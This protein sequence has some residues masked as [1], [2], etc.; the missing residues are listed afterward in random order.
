MALPFFFEAKM[1]TIAC[2]RI[3]QGFSPDYVNVLYDSVRRNLPA[4][5]E[6]RFVC[7]TDQPDEL[8]PGIEIRSTDEIFYYQGPTLWLKLNWCVVGPLDEIAQRGKILPEDVT[9]YTGAL[10]PRG[11]KI[12]SFPLDKLQAECGG[13]VKEVWKIGG[14]TVASF[15]FFCVTDQ[16][17]LA[18]NIRSAHRRDACWLQPMD[19]HNGTGIIVAGGPSL[20]RE[21]E[22]L[23]LHKAMGGRIFALNNTPAYLAQVGIRA[24][25]QILMDGQPEVVNYVTKQMPTQRFYCST[26]DPAVLDA[27]GGE[28][29]LWNALIEGILNVVPEAKD[30]FIGGGLTVGTRAIGLL[31]MLGYRKIHIY[32]LDSSYDGADGHAYQQG[33]YMTLL[34]VTAMGKTYRTSPQLLKQ[35]DEFQELLPEILKNGVCLYVHGEGLIPDIANALAS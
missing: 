11:T 12:V 27:A 16:E 21:L 2:I 8:D 34:D 4:G 5:M 1:L 22:S 25:A 30:P 10:F 26:C 28:L 13:W 24:D 3:G 15:E 23:K 20:R 18:E 7:F 19:A 9:P 31:Y 29:I 32:G 6:G 35:A 17:K 33:D 14:G